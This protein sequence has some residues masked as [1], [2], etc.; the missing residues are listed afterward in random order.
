MTGTG[1]GTRT[2]PG[3]GIRPGTGPGT[4]PGPGPA[5]RPGPGPEISLIIGAF[6]LPA[7]VLSSL[8]STTQ[9]FL[10]LLDCFLCLLN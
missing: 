2:G 7:N 9:S 4:G 8:I 10:G 5:T 3:P 6:R 1:T